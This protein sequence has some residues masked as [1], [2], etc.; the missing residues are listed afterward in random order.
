MKRTALLTGVACVLLLAAAAWAGGPGALAATYV[1]GWTRPTVNDVQ[2]NVN[3]TGL[4]TAS[5]TP[6][7]GT[8]AFEDLG[9]GLTR[10]WNSYTARP[11]GGTFTGT[12]SI[13]VQGPAGSTRTITSSTVSITGGTGKYN[14]IKDNGAGTATGSF[15]ASD[16]PVSLVFN[17]ASVTY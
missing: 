8:C 17:F 16:Q 9:G 3:V 14:K 12:Y 13:V 6:V 7:T 15:N 4:F 10:V 11:S 2:F 5:N 1:S